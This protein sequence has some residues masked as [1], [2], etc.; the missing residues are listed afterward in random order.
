M[1]NRKSK[2]SGLF[3]TTPVADVPAPHSASADVAQA[4]PPEATLDAVPQQDQ[5]QAPVPARAQ[6]AARQAGPRSTAPATRPTAAPAVPREQRVQVGKRNNPNYFQATAYIPQQLKEEVD[7]KIIRAKR[8][9][10]DLD[11][12]VLM[13]EL[14]QTWVN[15]K[16]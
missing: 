3:E 9:R 13:E 2:F 1:T 6:R 7:I 11:F 5:E 8:R 14:L 12:S 15:E 16:D 10:P 4:A